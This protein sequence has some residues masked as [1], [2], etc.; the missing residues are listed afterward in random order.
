MSISRK[1]TLILTLTRIRPP[2]VLDSRVRG[3]PGV[4]NQRPVETSS[5]RRM[6]LLERRVAA[7]ERRV[8]GDSRDS[9]DDYD[10]KQRL[11]EVE[12]KLERVEGSIVDLLAIKPILVK[13]NIF[14]RE[15]RV[16]L[17]QM[18]E[19]AEYIHATRH[20]VERQ[21][22]LLSLIKDVA[23]VVETDILKGAFESADSF[24]C[25]DL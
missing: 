2:S 4:W 12:S 10:V 11:S 24:P 15:R 17:Q 20:V 23:P 21:L 8:F 18:G 1:V 14:L 3:S 7:I 6:S 25:V 9:R 19:R 13:Y 16:P 22:N 5:G